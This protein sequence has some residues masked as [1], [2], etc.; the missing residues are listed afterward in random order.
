MEPMTPTPEDLNRLLQENPIAMQE[1]RAIIA[2]RLLREAM[3]TIA[4]GTNGKVPDEEEWAET[5]DV[6]S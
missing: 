2:E 4:K 3:E 6:G 5:I 1:L